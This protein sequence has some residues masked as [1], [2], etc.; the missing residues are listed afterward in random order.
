[1]KNQNTSEKLLARISAKDAAPDCRS[2]ARGYSWIKKERSNSWIDKLIRLRC[3]I[4][5]CATVFYD[6][7]LFFFDH[8]TQLT[9]DKGEQNFFDDK[10]SFEKGTLCSV[11][12][13]KRLREKVMQ[14]GC[15]GVFA[16]IRPRFFK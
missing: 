4:S 5:F 9:I 10:W 2:F 11:V 8:Y 12:Y 3:R 7:M 13:N 16:G 14:R 1:M 6:A 15:L